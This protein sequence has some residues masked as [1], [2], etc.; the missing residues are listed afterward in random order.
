MNNVIIN[1]VEYDALDVLKIDYT[2][3]ADRMDKRMHESALDGD[4]ANAERS[5][6][7][8]DCYEKFISDL[9]YYLAIENKK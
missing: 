4:F 1:G 6:I 8:R 2:E 7:K 5:K 9:K 3:L